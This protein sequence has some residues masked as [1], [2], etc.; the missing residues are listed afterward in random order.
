M[1]TL[2]SLSLLLTFLP[3]LSVRAQTSCNTRDIIVVEID[4]DV[5]GME[6]LKFNGEA[7]APPAA[8]DEFH[9]RCAKITVVLAT[10]R[11]R[12]S[13]LQ[14]FP[15]FLGKIGVPVDETNFFIFEADPSN[16]QA[17]GMTYLK[18]FKTIPFTR[19]PRELLRIT[20]SPPKQNDFR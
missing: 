13:Q 1:K 16:S 6:R 20:A 11:V 19:D 17:R 12:L 2:V 10:P 4:N 18:N 7:I 3:A 15:F 14:A 5:G 9:K 8:F